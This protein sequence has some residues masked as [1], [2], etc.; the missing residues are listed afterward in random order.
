M[1]GASI[2]LAPAHLAVLL[3]GGMPPTPHGGSAF[4]TDRAEGRCSCVLASST[5]GSVAPHAFRPSSQDPIL[6]RDL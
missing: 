6:Q 2:C 4:N 5:S 3:G 1:L